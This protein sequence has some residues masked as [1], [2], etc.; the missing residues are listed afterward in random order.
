LENQ[1]TVESEEL[2]PW[3]LFIYAMKAPMTKDRYKTRVV[4]FFDFI[5]LDKE[6]KIVQDKARIFANRGKE[7]NNW[8]F[9]NV[10][11][12][13]HFQ[14]ERVDRKE[15]S[16]ATVRNYAKSIKL[17]C[18]MADIPI[19]WKKITRGLPR[20][21][22]YADDRIPTLE[23]IRKLVEYPDRRIKA[24]VYTMASSGIRVG[25]WDYLQWGHI[26][27]IENSDGEVIAAKMIV[28]AGE[29]EEYFTFISPEALRALQEWMSYRQSSGECTSENSWLMRDLWDT[30]VAQGRGLASL[31]KKLS[32]LGLKRLMERA[33]WAQGLRKKLEPGKKRHPYQANHSLRKWFKTH[34][35]IAGMKPINIEKLM[36]HSVGI[37]DS[38][39]KATE[40]ELLE[41]YLKSVGLLEINGDKTAL[42]KQVKTLRERNE[43]SEYL[44]KAKLQE[45]DDQLKTMQDQFAR[46]QSQVHLIMSSLGAIDQ[47]SKNELA[48]KMYQSGVYRQKTTD[49]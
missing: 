42:Q 47:S 41:D 48:R 28:Y 23:E 30:R 37:S 45:K 24:I 26:R 33:I 31:P 49:V 22:K 19:P 38:Y 10:L 25:A 34:C 5:G 13:I 27:P 32:S 21:K 40:S 39:Y 29:D 4:K 18:D 1:K 8:A 36:N 20:G 2:D 16:G 46:L 43:E 12:F 35:E 6:G 17:F 9:S 15:I 11:R 14:K 7:D 44:V 3:S